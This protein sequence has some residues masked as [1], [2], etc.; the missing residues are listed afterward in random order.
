M[1]AT[2]GAG[3]KRMG[4]SLISNARSLIFNH[5][6]RKEEGKRREEICLRRTLIG[7][8]RIFFTKTLRHYHI[9]VLRRDEVP[10]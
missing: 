10:C 2:R 3:R 8:R 7:Y 1:H 6:E 4:V 9:F 5:Q